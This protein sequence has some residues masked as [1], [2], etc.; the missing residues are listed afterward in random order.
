MS[1]NLLQVI[2]PPV[3]W[4]CNLKELLLNRNS[5]SHMAVQPRFMTQGDLW[6]PF[7]NEEDGKNMF[8]NCL[9]KEKLEFVEAYDGKGIERMK[10]LSSSEVSYFKR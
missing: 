5:I 10:A 2:P 7:I 6:K 9:T 8:L 1:M 4:M 3:V